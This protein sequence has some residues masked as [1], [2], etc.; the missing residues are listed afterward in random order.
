MSDPTPNTG[1][2]APTGESTTTVAVGTLH[3]V[4]DPPPPAAPDVPPTGGGDGRDGQRPP[5]RD[6][7]ILVPGLGNAPGTRVDDVALRIANAMDNCAGD[8]RAVFSVATRDVE[9]GKD[10]KVRTATILRHETAKA[11]G[12]PLV[13]LYE[14]EYASRLSRGFSDKP[15]Y[16]QA[17]SIAGTL[18]ANTPNLLAAFSRR[19]KGLAQKLQILYGATFFGMLLL[20]LVLLVAAVIGTGARPGKAVEQK[21]AAAV[22]QDADAPPAAAA[23]EPAASG[24]VEPVLR[25]AEPAVAVPLQKDADQPWWQRVRNA[26]VRW[27]RT[28]PWLDWAKNGIV[29]LT[30]AGFVVKFN[31]RNALSEAAPALSSVTD[32][33]A[34]GSHRNEIIG[35]LARLIN[36]LDESPPDDRPYRNIH[37]AAYSFGSV[38]AIDALFQSETAVSPRFARIHTLITIGSPFDFIRTFWP[39]YFTERRARP[40]TPVRW[41]N[42]F[43]EVDVLGSNFLD[44]PSWGEKRRYRRA[45][46]AEKRKIEL[47]WTTSLAQGVDLRDA[48][49]RRPADE[50]NVPFGPGQSGNLSLADWARLAGF[51]VHAVYWDRQ[52]PAAVSCFEPIVTRL[53]ADDTE[54]RVLA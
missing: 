46:A 6:A 9:V 14:F 24:A 5:V 18:L 41:I 15:P 52:S 10:R 40:G 19:S 37:I 8:A 33:L 21:T 29:V 3:L 4:G 49:M 12:R 27:F 54:L 32:Y 34:A 43:S 16:R 48:G 28:G 35:E 30:L 26:L 47:E 45:P 53:Y 44:E 20:Y 22:V 2:A 42:V 23:A 25:A 1:G 38:V 11:E 39:N 13:D 50:D 17:L 36:H 31:V 7:I 51:R